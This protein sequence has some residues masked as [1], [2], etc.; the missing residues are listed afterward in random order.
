MSVSKVNCGAFPLALR[1]R[2]PQAYSGRY[3]PGR[4]W[5]IPDQIAEILKT[6]CLTHLTPT[7]G[8]GSRISETYHTCRWPLDTMATPVH[9]SVFNVIR[10]PIAL[11]T[12]WQI[13]PRHPP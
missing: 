10:V 6:I 4:F 3:P 5:Q 9:E 12:P 13:H 11:S 8:T 2:V 7:A 1:K